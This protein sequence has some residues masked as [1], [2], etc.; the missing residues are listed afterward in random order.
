[1]NRR[2]WMQGLSALGVT[3]GCTAAG[4]ASD[5]GKMDDSKM[6]L[7][8]PAKN[9][10]LHFCGIH[11]AKAN[12]KFQVITQ[13]YCGARS[14]DMHQC[15]LYDSCDKNAKLL[16]VEYIIS[17]KLFQTL[18]P[19]EKKYWHV[20]TYEVL[21]GGL[22]GP[23]MK[24]D[25]ENAFM[26]YIMT[27]W[28]KTWHTWPDP[29]TPVPMGEPLLMWSLT[30]DGQAD[31]K[32]IAERDKLFGVNCQEI[33]ERRVKHFGLEVPQVDLPKSINDLGRQWTN[34]GPDTP[35]KRR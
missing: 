32:V 34:Q 24:L 28:G 11:I 7:M 33:R 18:P 35:T 15:L 22:T 25:D 6:D 14:E 8:A 9:S 5:H 31:E 1:M 13:H 10:H 26:K 3:V 30:G 29:K 20:H 12:P 23:G 19:E 17:D 21:A 27:T 2:D 16:G 4:L